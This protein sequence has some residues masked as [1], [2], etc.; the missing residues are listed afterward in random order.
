MCTL[1]SFN[2]NPIIADLD[3]EHNELAQ[4]WKTFIRHLPSDDRVDWEH[5]PQ[6]KD[7]VNAL[8][9]SLQ[10]FWMARPRQRVY[11]Q[12]RV[13]CEQFL[14]TIDTHAT[15]LARLPDSDLYHTPTFYGALQSVLKVS[16]V[17]VRSNIMH[18]Y[19]GLRCVNMEKFP[20]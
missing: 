2:R 17:I 9:R 7:D 5:R 10:S 20:G 11:S 8:I 6:T 1:T 3:V 19:L 13:L 18:I 14:P 4:T 12:A 15:L 16:F